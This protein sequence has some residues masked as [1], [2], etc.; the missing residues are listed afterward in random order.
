MTQ[1]HTNPYKA[2]LW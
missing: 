2:T 1:R